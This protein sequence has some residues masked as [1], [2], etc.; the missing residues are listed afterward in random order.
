MFEVKTAQDLKYIM[1]YSFT[2]LIM[3]SP[4]ERERRRKVS[5]TK[6][7][8]SKNFELNPV[9]KPW[10]AKVLKLRFRIQDLEARSRFRL[11]NPEHT[12]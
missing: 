10:I 8:D 9:D 1:M 12:I 3:G 11:W 2:V 6:F 4:G 5:D 7:F